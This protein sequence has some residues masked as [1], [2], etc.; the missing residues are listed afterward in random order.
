MGRDSYPTP[1]NSVSSDI[2][3]VGGDDAVLGMLREGP[4]GRQY[5]LVQSHDVSADFSA[6]KLILALKGGQ[7]FKVTL[8]ADTGRCSG[9]AGTSKVVA[10]GDYFWML[11]RGRSDLVLVPSGT[12]GTWIRSVGTGVGGSITTGLVGNINLSAGAGSEAF[13]LTNCG[14]IGWAIT[15]ADGT[16]SLASVEVNPGFQWIGTGTAVSAVTGD[17]A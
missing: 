12:A 15:A 4:D 14:V 3:K 16:T 1:L 8:A 5:V 10:S 13:T 7:S 9:I 17:E 11:V 6:G 2:K